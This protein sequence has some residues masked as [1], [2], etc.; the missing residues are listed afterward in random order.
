MKRLFSQ[1]AGAAIVAGAFAFAAPA[2]AAAFLQNWYLDTDGAGAGLQT[3]INEYLDITGNSYIRLTPGAGS[4]FTFADDGFF[5]VTGHDGVGRPKPNYITAT[6]TDGAGTGTFGGGI[7]FTPGVGILNVYSDP[8]DN[9]GDNSS[10]IFGA[11]DG[12]LIGSFLMYQG[13]GVVDSTGVPNGM[14]TLTMQATMLAPGY[15]FAPDGTTDLSTLVGGGLLFGFVTTNASTVTDLNTDVSDGLALLSG[16]PV[17][18]DVKQGKFVV[19]N[20]GQYRL[21]VVPE[22]GTTALLGLGL[23]SA[24]LVARRRS[25]EK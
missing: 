14:L 1:V 5:Q 11:N 23:L 21:S 22:P 19:S 18:N 10:S 13:V 12:T 9:W 7:T 2:S 16:E 3:K 6:F 8:V 15:F 20:N 4:S 24:M 17:V 25:K